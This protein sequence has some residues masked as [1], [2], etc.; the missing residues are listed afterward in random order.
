M[1]ATKKPQTA[2][3]TTLAS[4]RRCE[5]L[6]DEIA[7]K[8]TFISEA[9]VD[10]GV[11]LVE[12]EKKELFKTLGYTTFGELLTER[13]VFGP[14][15]A[16]KLMAIAR[17][18]PRRHALALGTEK[19]YAL[20]RYAKATAK[21]DFAS[22]L[23]EKGIPIAGKLRPVADLSA[24]ELNQEARRTS[25]NRRNA[26]RDPER[27]QALATVTEVRARLAKRGVRMKTEVHKARGAWVV[28]VEM[29]VEDFATLR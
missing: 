28:T 26:T 7:R 19:A 20:V 13:G 2:A 22:Q 1:T 5:E 9:F 18:L 8:K 25:R 4:R 10:I 14:S 6:L 29:S 24:A 11:A 27:H 12:I 23:V 3:L 21:I 17:S 15:Q 16:Y